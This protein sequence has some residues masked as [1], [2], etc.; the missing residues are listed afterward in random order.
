M[1]RRK[2]VP[3]VL[4]YLFYREQVLM[5][6]RNRNLKSDYHLGK[7]NGL[8]GKLEPDESALEAALRETREECGLSTLRSVLSEHG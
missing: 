7:W 1:G 8:G 4:V 3:A 6:H 5:L 2:M